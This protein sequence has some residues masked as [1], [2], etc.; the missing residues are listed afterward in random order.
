MANLVQNS[1]GLY[2]IRF[3]LGRKRFNR[4]LETTIEKE[5]KEEKA[6]I[7]KTL[8][9]IEEGEK[10]LPDNATPEQVWVFLR[11][12]GKRTDKVKLAAAVSLEKVAEEYFESLPEGAKEQSSLNTE[13]TH[14]KNLK[15]HLRA[16]T[17]LYELT[18]QRVQ[19]YVSK[20]QKDRGHGGKPIK[21]DT[22]KKEIQTFRQLWDFAAARGYV[23]GSCPVDDVV[24]PKGDDKPPFKTWEEIETTIKRGGYAEQEQKE[25]WDSLF[26]RDE[27]IERLLD[28]VRHAAA[29]PFIYPMFAF[30]AYTGARR[31]EII[32]SEVGDFHLDEGYVLIREKKRRTDARISYRDVALHPRL[33]EIMAEWL[34]RHPG[35]RYTISVP[36]G[37]IR[38][39]QK[40][41][42]PQPLTESQAHD[43]FQRTLEESKWKVVRGF[44]VLRHSFASN[45]ARKGVHQLIINRWL[46]HQTEEM[47]R[48]YR[49]LFPEEKRQ[50]MDAMSKAAY[51]AG[52]P[53]S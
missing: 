34:K 25:L 43:H 39:K 21:A 26:L 30:T 7:E 11:S 28:H 47:T 51:S 20:R 27:E 15:R 24:L 32:R 35:G 29:H 48:R 49:H 16:S 42:V 52:N 19:G 5:A 8:R 41:E 4:S 37:M 40:S 36:P 6:K 46:G 13:Q 22:I 33:K 10:D 9:L 44:H 53:S 2:S 50:A 23:A 18:V 1:S 31:S 17:P 14:V 12:G 38:S 3:R 45:L